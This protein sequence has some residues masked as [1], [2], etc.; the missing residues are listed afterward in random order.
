MSANIKTLYLLLGSLIFIS[1]PIV[2]FFIGDFPQRTLLK[3]SISIITIVS[4]FA[5]IGQFYLSKINAGITKVFKIFKVIKIHKI[6]GYVFTYPYYS[7]F[8]NNLAKVF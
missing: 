8:F 4:F 1:L 2:F 5:I 6:L 3:D 7:S